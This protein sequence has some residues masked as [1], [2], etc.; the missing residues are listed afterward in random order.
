[1]RRAASPYLLTLGLSHA[2]MSLVFIAGPL[3]GLIVQPLV[4]LLA[5]RSSS[6][7]GRRR[8]F[9]VGGTIACVLGMLLLGF[10]RQVSNLFTTPFSEPVSRVLSHK[11]IDSPLTS[12]A[13]NRIISS[14][15]FLQLCQSLLSTSLSMLCRL[16]IVL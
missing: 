6:K 16:W 12:R 14:R 5:D 4:G 15:S 13:H 9:I 7:W 3:S 8:P 1:M 2:L 11:F 10:T